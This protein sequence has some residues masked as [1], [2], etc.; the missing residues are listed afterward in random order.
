MS[1]REYSESYYNVRS[2]T[3]NSHFQ[4]AIDSSIFG[5]SSPFAPAEM[6]PWPSLR[7]RDSFKHGYLQKLELN[8]AHMKRSQSRRQG[9]GQQSQTRADNRERPPATA[10]LRSSRTALRRGPCWPACSSSPGTPSC[11]SRAAASAAEVYPIDSGFVPDCSARINHHPSIFLHV[12]H[13]SPLHFPLLLFVLL[14]FV[15]QM[16]YITHQSPQL[17]RSSAKI[18]TLWFGVLMLLACY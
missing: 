13:L 4:E 15:V 14:S 6:H 12:Y 2:A 17:F 9:Q 8:L 7:I 1:F 10:R 16:I 3:M 5:I 18:D 11:S